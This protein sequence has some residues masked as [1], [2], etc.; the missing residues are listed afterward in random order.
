LFNPEPAA[1]A[2]AVPVERVAVA[3]GSGLNERGGCGD[4]A[5]GAPDSVED[6]ALMAAGYNSSQTHWVPD[7]S[8]FS[9]EELAN[10]GP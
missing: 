10:V 6:A 4:A 1:T 9:T 3:A 5:L 8:T 2:F 7:K